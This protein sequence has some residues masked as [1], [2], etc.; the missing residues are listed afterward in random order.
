MIRRPSLLVPVLAGLL[1]IPAACGGGNGNPRHTSSAASEAG[2]D[3]SHLTVIA[4]DIF[5]K[6]K[7]ATVAAGQVKVTYV[8]EGQ[9][10]HT[11][12]IEGNKDLRLLVEENGEEDTGSVELQPGDYNFYCDV[13]G[14]RSAGM[15]LEVHVQ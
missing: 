10:M 7:E 1:V 14:H 2:A 15:E 5:A 4:G 12:V 11:L 13:P 3:R 6:P 9:I 8:N